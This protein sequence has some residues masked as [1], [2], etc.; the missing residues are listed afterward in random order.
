MYGL[1]QVDDASAELHRMYVA[2]ESVGSGLR[3]FHF[4]KALTSGTGA[5]QRQ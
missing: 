1:E 4:E 2:T 5:R 3:R